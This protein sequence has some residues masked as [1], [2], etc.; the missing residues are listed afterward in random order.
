MRIEDDDEYWEYLVLDWYLAPNGLPVEV[1]QTKSSRSDTF[2]GPVEYVEEYHLVLT[3]MD[4][5][6]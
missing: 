4:P 6:P 1:T 2:V 5:L 3:S